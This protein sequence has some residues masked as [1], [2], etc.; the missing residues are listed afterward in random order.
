MDT[1]LN[2][3]MTGLILAG[4]KS[5]RMGGSD[6]AFAPLNGRA[7]VAYVLETLQAQVS[8]VMFSAN[9]NFRKYAQLGCKVVPDKLDSHAGPLAGMASGLALATTPYLLVVPCDAPLVCKNLGARLFD[10]LI[11]A[12]TTAAVAHDGAR[13]QPVFALLSTSL[14]GTVDRYLNEGGRKVD[15][16]YSAIS[17]TTVDFS[18]VAESFFNVNTP[19]DLAAISD[20]LRGSGALQ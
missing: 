7:V 9:R 17:A 5:S 6:K 19:D 1:V 15:A 4:G 11:S 3:Q 10:A 20:E 18:D 16:F 8:E 2:H 14:G 13:L 12:G